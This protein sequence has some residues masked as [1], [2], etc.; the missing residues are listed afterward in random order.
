MRLSLNG[1]EVTLSGTTFT[2]HVLPFPDPSGLREFR[3]QHEPDWFLHWR[4][5]LLYGIPRVEVPT[6]AFGQAR[7]L[8]WSD[9]QHLQ[10]LTARLND[11][12]P[13]AFPR[14]EALHRRPFAFLSLKDELVDAVTSDWKGVPALLS[15]FTIRP[16]Y[17]LEAKIIELRQ[18][19]T[20]PA[21]FMTVRMQWDT[22]ADLDA[23]VAAGVDVAGLYVVRRDPEPGQRRLVGRIKAISAARVQLSESHGDLT[24]IG[25]ADVY[26]EPSRATFA[27]CLGVL[28][29]R[30]FDE[31]EN[32]REERQDRF[33]SGPALDQL[34][35]TMQTVLR[36]ASP[37]ALTPDLS[38]NI[39]ERL[40]LENVS[41]YQSALRLPPVEYCYDAAK[42]KRHQFAWVGL[43]KFGAYS[44]DTFSKRTPKILVVVPDRAA[45]QVSQFVK[46]FRDGVDSIE[47]SSYAAGFSRTFGL[48]NPQ[49]VT[50]TV[51][52]SQRSSEASADRYARSVEEHLARDSDYQAAIAVILD[53]EARLPD[54]VNPYLRAKAV[55]LMNGIPVQEARLSTLTKPPASLQ[56]TMQN[57]AVAL[58]AKMGGVPWTVAHDLGV[59]DE[60]VIGMGMAE[61]SGS[62]FQ[63]RQRHMGITTVFRGDG[64]YLL[65]SVAKACSYT[66]YPDVLRTAT[67]DVLREVKTRNGWRPGDTIRIVF[68]LSKPLKHIEMAEIVN[69]AVLEV[70]R[71]QT[72]QFAFLTVSHDH[73]FKILDSDQAGI[74]ARNGRKARFVPDR[75]TMAQV[76]QATRLLCTNGPQQ[77]KRPTTPLPSPLLVHLHPKSS[78]NDLAYLTEQALKFTSLTW[79]STQ[80]AYSPVTIFYSELIAELLARLQNL[81]GW[82]PAVLNSKL[83]TSR[84]FL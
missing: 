23:L 65:A 63:E 46:L 40:R 82:S 70:G 35:D 45:G 39:G 81:P 60:L 72:V 75:G 34:L 24:S 41:G 6:L 59:D 1:F 49:F 17:E 13:T 30:R 57:I 18:G 19:E 68:H 52:V 74:Q 25:T 51:P 4:E 32:Q 15:A 61:L 67:A 3:A 9:H 54:H 27:R 78:Y 29:G 66:E 33:L 20:G 14:Y 21:L 2:A 37:V 84:W 12:L 48:V 5:G 16:R 71:E 11:V 69:D 80:P 56:Y 26:L 7:A 50:C 79:R 31:F 8:D 22:T 47:N 76:G 42:A 44:Q 62:R 58:Y 53:D 10:V 28:L 64:N 77:V 83:R 43:Q 73:G 36:K 38:C 55:L